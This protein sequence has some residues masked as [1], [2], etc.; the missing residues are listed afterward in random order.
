MY[1]SEMRSRFLWTLLWGPLQCRV[2]PYLSYMHAIR[3]HPNHGITYWVIS[4]ILV[5][6]GYLGYINYLGPKSVFSNDLI[7][8]LVFP[9]IK[10]LSFFVNVFIQISWSHNVY[11]T[12]QCFWDGSWYICSCGLLTSTGSNEQC[13]NDGWPSA[14][15]NSKE[16]I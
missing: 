9:S 5:A 4:T 14:T 3:I 13:N 10:S 15:K 12:I 2:G 7:V 11:Q 1:T 6:R 16:R 8:N